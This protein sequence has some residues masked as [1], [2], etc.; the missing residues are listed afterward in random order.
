MEKNGKVAHLEDCALVHSLD[1]ERI[2]A[3]MCLGEV[4]GMEDAIHKITG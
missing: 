1:A 4:K 2:F 3:S